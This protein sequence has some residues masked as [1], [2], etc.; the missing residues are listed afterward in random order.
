VQLLRVYKRS[1][2]RICVI[3]TPLTVIACLYAAANPSFAQHMP[4]LRYPSDLDGRCGLH[5]SQS[6]VIGIHHLDG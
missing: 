1:V 6:A 3:L 5:V 4:M 2:L